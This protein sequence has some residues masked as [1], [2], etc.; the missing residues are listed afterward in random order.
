MIIII[1]INKEE[2]SALLAVTKTDSE[3][4]TTNTVL[5][6]YKH[7]YTRGGRLKF[8]FT[9]VH[10]SNNKIRMICTYTRTTW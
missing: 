5:C 1:I 4:S 3:T 7:N 2:E 6:F 9:Y 10:T 8:L